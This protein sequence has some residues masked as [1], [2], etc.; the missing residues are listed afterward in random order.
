MRDPV[1][2]ADAVAAAAAMVAQDQFP[3]LL[4]LGR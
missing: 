4:S 2:N 1:M 3:G